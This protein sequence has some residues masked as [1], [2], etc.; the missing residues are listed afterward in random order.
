MVSPR[1]VVVVPPL[2][3]H[4]V[5]LTTT[6][7]L[8]T[9][10]NASERAC[11]GSITLN[12]LAVCHQLTPRTPCTLLVLLSNL[13]QALKTGFASS[14]SS[15]SSRR[16]ILERERERNREQQKRL[17]PKPLCICLY[18]RICLAHVFASPA[19]FRLERLEWH[20]L[21]A[22]L[23]TTSCCNNKSRHDTTR[24]CGS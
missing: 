13:V 17:V 15:P 7:V 9:F 18:S 4:G 5:A 12:V 11:T 3:V 19:F 6:A 24:T 14:A 8:R 1:V 23:C 22:H 21:P 16:I 2:W 20:C 10:M